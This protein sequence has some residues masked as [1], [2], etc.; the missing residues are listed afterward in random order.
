M[1]RVLSVLLFLILPAPLLA[2]PALSFEA[3]AA[4][5]SGLTSGGKP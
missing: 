2:Q 3:Q 1:Y 4:V 5:A